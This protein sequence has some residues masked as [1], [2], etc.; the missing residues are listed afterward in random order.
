[1]QI[2]WA[3]FL[4]NCSQLSL[5]QLLYGVEGVGLCRVSRALPSHV[6]IVVT[7]EENCRD[8]YPP[9]NNCKQINLALTQHTINQP[10]ATNWSPG[11]TQV[12]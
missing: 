7:E 5:M 11:P 12:R 4:G 8:S 6:E 3:S 9:P 1:M 10:T 2:F